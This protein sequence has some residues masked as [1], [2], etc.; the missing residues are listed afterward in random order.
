MKKIVVCLSLCFFSTLSAYAERLKDIATIEG[1]RS[2][3]LIGY[4]LVVGLDGTGDQTNQ[5]PFTRQS[6]TSMLQQLGITVPDGA[7]FQLANVAA[8]ALHAELPPF[9]KPGQK[10][11][12]TASSIA[13][14]KSLRGG[15]LLMSPLRG[16]DGQVYAIAQGNFCLLYTS[17]AADDLTRVYRGF[18]GTTTKTHKHSR[19]ISIHQSISI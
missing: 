19:V 1:V 9:A 5:T 17:D 4:G 6:F 3:Q 16:V 12:I 15:T 18:P 14:A 10:I 2:N 11:D 7:N 8:V 13:N